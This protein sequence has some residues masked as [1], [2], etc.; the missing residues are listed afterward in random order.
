MLCPV[1]CLLEVNK[2]MVEILL[3]LH[4]LFTEDSKGR[5]I[6]SVVLCFSISDL[7]FSDDVLCLWL[8]P[9]KDDLQHDFAWVADCPVVTACLVNFLLI[10]IEFYKA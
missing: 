2:A 4:V 1:K 6:C 7:F 5:N 9:V 3:L 10:F 8:E